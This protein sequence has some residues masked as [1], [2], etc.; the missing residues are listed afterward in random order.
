MATATE[1][2]PP[3]SLPRT[4]RRWP[5]RTLIAL[6][7]LAAV[8]LALR[9][10]APYYLKI[11]IDRRLGQIPGYS[12]RVDAVSVH[13]WRGAYGMHGLTI[14]K[15]GERV[16]EPFFS[17]ESIDFS[18]AWRELF[19]G[20]LVSQIYARNAHLTFERGPDEAST[21]LSADKRW[22]DVIN[23]L[24]PI[25]ITLLDVKGGVLR[26]VDATH[27]PKVDIAVHDLRL[28]ATGLQNRPSNG[29]DA[30]PARIDIS[31]I[32]LGHGAFRMFAKAEP[33]AD[34]AHF[35]LA[36]E[37]KKVS[38]PAL[39]DFLR[40]YANVEV[41]NGQFDVFA[42]MAMAND[43]YEG[44][45]KPFFS[46]LA[47]TDRKNDD[48]VGHRIWT[49]IVAGVANLVKNKETKQVATRIPFS[50]EASGLNVHTW[51][52]IENALHHGFVKEL[53]RGFE[54]TPNPDH[55]APPLVSD[56]APR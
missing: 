20:R 6:L 17:A 22:Q 31:G 35:Q 33:L 52:T 13:I 44:Y 41:S 48:S 1:A 39:N 24:F 32:T 45:V 2:A 38:L 53:S 40:A 15:R 26:F 25:D 36:M 5:R 21:Q 37:L 51:K 29:G 56:K 7:A 42:Q 47:F 14:V 50:G 11:A 8:L 3:P 9:L 10:A 55:V 4:P 18:I 43:H 46:D 16:P 28:T 34:K 19:R 54:G 12:G 49:A 30:Y 23:D 27:D